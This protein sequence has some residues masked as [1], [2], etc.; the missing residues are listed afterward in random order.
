MIKSSFVTLFLFFVSEIP[1]VPPPSPARSVDDSIM[2]NVTHPLSPSTSWNSLVVNCSAS[3]PPSLSSKS[4]E[5]LEELI[6]I[7]LNRDAYE[8]TGYVDPV[9]ISELKDKKPYLDDDQSPPDQWLSIQD[10][11]EMA[12]VNNDEFRSTGAIPRTQVTQDRLASR[13]VEFKYKSF[14][15]PNKHNAP[16]TGMSLDPNIPNQTEQ[17][18]PEDS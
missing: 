11:T 6:R 10:P 7:S 9:P 16:K 14:L 15:S 4:E 12:T 1:E 8:I 17:G 13:T 2:E 5:E 18:T 3:G